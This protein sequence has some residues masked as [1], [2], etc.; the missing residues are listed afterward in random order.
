MFFFKSD[1][2]NKNNDG[3]VNKRK[4]M[5]LWPF[6]HIKIES[7][8]KQDEIINLINES[9][10]QEWK[11]IYWGKRFNK[12]FWGKVGKKTF[13]IRPVV[14]YW[15]ISPVEIIGNIKDG[16]EDTNELEI[17]MRC[18][19]FRIILPLVIIAVGLFFA[20]F[21]LK[22]EMDI[23]INSSLIIL[24]SAYLLV[25]IPFQIQSTWSL[26]HLADQFNGNLM[27][28]Q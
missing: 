25:N 11:S 13:R 24:V 5:I 9:T 8:Y 21:G 10:D 7:R 2:V 3:F 18:P 16:G 23:F 26:K 4:I 12:R 1:S 6:K 19:Y 27:K 15:N 22:G 14:P 28:V 20:N 17:K